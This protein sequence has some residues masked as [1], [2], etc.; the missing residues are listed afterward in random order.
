[1]RAE[2]K[3]KFIAQLRFSSNELIT[4]LS[5]VI[6]FIILR[7]SSYKYVDLT[8]KSKTI[9]II[10]LHPPADKSLNYSIIIKHQRRTQI[11]LN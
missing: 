3:Y 4:T 10:S 9:F 5:N 11:D 2:L 6:K 1:M 8:P 7:V